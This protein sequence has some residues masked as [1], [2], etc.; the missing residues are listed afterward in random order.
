MTPT[1]DD[2]IDPALPTPRNNNR[3]PSVESAQHGSGG[4]KDRDARRA[5][6]QAEAEKMR[7]MLEEN[8]RELAALGRE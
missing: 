5:A 3:E 2:N 4:G 8:E 6:L 7:R 1:S